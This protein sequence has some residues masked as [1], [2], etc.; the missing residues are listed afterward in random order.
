MDE[1]LK[2]LASNENIELEHFDELLKSTESQLELIRSLRN[3]IKN[4]SRYTT[5]NYECYCD[6]F[7]SICKR[8]RINE[9]EDNQ[10]FI[11]LFESISRNQTDQFKISSL[12]SLLKVLTV[13]SEMDKLSVNQAEVVI[14]SLKV[15]LDTVIETRSLM[16]SYEKAVQNFI[17]LFDG[18]FIKA[19]SISIISFVE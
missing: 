4:K 17:Y 7:E 11:G 5:H 16:K 9:L 8:I 1:F 13:K 12:I 14:S 10:K 18:N 19:N 3:L 15:D 6:I 2:S